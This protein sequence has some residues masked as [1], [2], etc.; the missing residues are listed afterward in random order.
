LRYIRNYLYHLL[1]MLITVDKITSNSYTTV[2][3]TFPFGIVHC[4]LHM[5]KK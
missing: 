5:Q 3:L 1:F 4:Y 2:I